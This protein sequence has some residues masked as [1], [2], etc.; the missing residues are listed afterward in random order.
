MTTIRFTKM[1][2]LGNDFVD[3]YKGLKNKISGHEIKYQNMTSHKYNIETV[4]TY[5]QECSGPDVE[6][7]WKQIK[8]ANLPYKRENKLAKI[9]KRSK[10]NNDL[11]YDF[12][13]DVIVPYQQE[14]L[15]T[16]E[17]AFLLSNYLGNFEKKIRK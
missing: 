9:L 6:E 5:F 8:E 10:I 14:G 16:E 3:F 4:F 11:E 13:T 17:Q 12:V 15:I 2:G 1:H 7:F